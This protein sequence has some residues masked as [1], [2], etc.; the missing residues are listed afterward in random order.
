MLCHAQQ[1]QPAAAVRYHFGDDLRWADPAFDDS[2]WQ[3]AKNGRMPAPPAAPDGF[4]WTRARVTMPGDAYGPLAIRVNDIG[5]LSSAV[6][7]ELFVN[8]QSVARR[9]SFPPQRRACP[10][11]SRIGV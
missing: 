10:G 6:S 8:G 4:E 2:A 11:S 7:F 9:G 1:A 5:L 3:V